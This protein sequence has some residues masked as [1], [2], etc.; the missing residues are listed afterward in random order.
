MNPRSAGCAWQVVVAIAIAAGPGCG[1]SDNETHSGGPPPAVVEV[2][3]VQPTS[4]RDAVS[5]AGQLDADESVMLRPETSGI[6]EE[7]AFEEGQEVAE[8]DVLFHL[9]D[10]EQRARLAAAKADLV[11]AERNHSRAAALRQEGVLAVED[12]DRA[13]AELAR[14]RAAVEVAEVELARTVIRA[15]FDGIA[16]RRFVSPGDH[17]RGGGGTGNDGTGLVEVDAVATLQ[18]LFSVPERAIPLMT[19]GMPVAVSVTP[20][21][22]ERFTGSVDFVAPSVDPQN[23]RLLV[24]AD[25]PNPDRRLRPGLSATVHLEIGYRPEAIVVPESALVYDAGGS[26]VWR[27]TEDGTAA[28]VAVEVGTRQEGRAEILAGLAAGDRIVSAGTNK[29]APGRPVRGERATAHAGPAAR[30]ES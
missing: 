30:T 11:L 29:V 23:R 26:F 28:R 17:V 19:V 8:G 20:Y 2:V 24:K 22:D 5:F 21:P 10:D 14:A 18:L 27:V 3:T 12:Y 4:L 6:V 1:R 9:R 13:F 15:P 25:I 7:I 16:G